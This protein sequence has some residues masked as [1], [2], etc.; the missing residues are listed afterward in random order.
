MQSNLLSTD[1]KIVQPKP[2]RIHLRD[3]QKT[4][5]HAMQSREKYRVPRS[6]PSGE[7][8]AYWGSDR[9][10]LADETGRGKTLSILG[11]VACGISPSGSYYVE[12]DNGIMV[13]PRDVADTGATLIVVPHT[14]YAQW[15]EFIEEDT[16]L[17]AFYLNSNSDFW[18][19]FHLPEDA[20]PRTADQFEKMQKGA[21]DIEDIVE[22]LKD[23]QIV[24]LNLKRVEMW[25]RTLTPLH[26]P[27]VVYDEIHQ[28]EIPRKFTLPQTSH[29]WCIS[30]D[31]TVDGQPHPN[32]R[33]LGYS[34]RVEELGNY[35]VRTNGEYAEE[36]MS[37]LPCEMMV[38]IC[39]A[40]AAVE[41]LEGLVSEK[42]MRFL[43]AGN[44]A[45]AVEAASSI[46]DSCENVLGALMR[47]MD[48]KIS[49]LEGL[50]HTVIYTD[51]Y[52]GKVKEERLLHLTDE[53]GRFQTRKNAIR[54]RITEGV[55]EAC[56]I[57]AED[58]VLPTMMKCCQTVYCFT[59]VQ[60]CIQARGTCP[61]CRTEAGE[62][63]YQVISEK[64][65][66]PVQ[67]EL[68]FATLNKDSTLIQILQHIRYN[69]PSPK[70]LL[71]SDQN[72]TLFRAGNMI[73]AI[74][75]ETVKLGGTPASVNKKIRLFRKGEIQVL[76]LNSKNFG[77]GLNLQ[78]AN[79]LIL[80]HRMTPEVEHQVI[81]R[82]DRPGRTRNLV[83]L[84]ILL[85]T[86]AKPDG[87][88]HELV[89]EDLDLVC[90]RTDDWY[91]EYDE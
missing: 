90:C 73:N 91:R 50:L 35:Y 1:P 26:W 67:P 53:I 69:D 12:S 3:H 64:V 84:Y 40:S 19:F 13:I 36:S 43:A 65:T 11:L 60:K 29:L 44:H 34:Q 74:G 77:S 58:M 2:L 66:H 51:T 6:P 79:Y 46:S 5:I 10:I 76:T 71:F 88:V 17:K 89:A 54:E 70:V 9:G 86:E 27:R 23:Y 14:L 80:M 21:M 56:M 18:P 42:V 72:E 59:C 38:I 25:N 49:K 33:R 28:L 82:A 63:S 16:K 22:V 31:P 55:G 87:K 47:D 39:K 37:T 81:S 85:P 52:C 41:M 8:T 20:E 4:V 48:D 45:Q 78:A 83:V 15:K 68:D 61:L 62:E 75:M 30:A 57:C 7:G 32:L 24:L